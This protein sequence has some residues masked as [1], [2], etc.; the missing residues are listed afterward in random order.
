MDGVPSPL[1]PDQRHHPMLLYMRSILL[2]VPIL[3]VSTPLLSQCVGGGSCASADEREY[4][5]LVSEYETMFRHSTFSDSSLAKHKAAL[6]DLEAKLRRIVGPFP[7]P[8][9][10]QPGEMN[11]DDMFA[12]D[13]DFDKMDGIRYQW[14]DSGI[15]QMNETMAVVST[16]PIV[17]DWLRRHK[18]SDT[19]PLDAAFAKQNVVTW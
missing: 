2:A 11:N 7:V 9:F 17:R 19:L 16:E 12:G 18:V 3:F 13:M 15:V 10:V 4:I 6:K 1:W 14:P 8:L 5:R